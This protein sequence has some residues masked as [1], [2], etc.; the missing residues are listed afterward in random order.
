MLTL[1][2]PQTV[3]EFHINRVQYI[4]YGNSSHSLIYKLIRP[5]IIEVSNLIQRN[6]IPVHISQTTRS[7][8]PANFPAGTGPYNFGHIAAYVALAMMGP[9]EEDPVM[10]LWLPAE[11][12]A[13]LGPEGST[14]SPARWPSGGGGGGGWGGPGFGPAGAGG[15]SGS[16][17]TPPSGGP[18]SPAPGS[19][20]LTQDSMGMAGPDPN[21]VPDGRKMIDQSQDQGTTTI[22]V[23]LS[24][25]L[26][27]PHFPLSL[28]SWFQFHFHKTDN[29]NDTW[30]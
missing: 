14:R 26:L 6:G 4:L 1:A 22:R 20:S 12:V 15:P 28:H 9:V 18:S 27:V 5:N 8:L 11:Q 19:S 23:C 2:S 7:Q 21:A 25:N 16:S 30:Y 10:R 13:G 3:T 24:I 17:G 29:D